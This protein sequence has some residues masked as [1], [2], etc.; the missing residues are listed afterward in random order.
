MAVNGSG[1]GCLQACHSVVI[2]VLGKM[3]TPA[4]PETKTTVNRFLNNLE[5]RA[6]ERME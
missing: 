3:T 4:M 2:N 5:N 1:S 6:R